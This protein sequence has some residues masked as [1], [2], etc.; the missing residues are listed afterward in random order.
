[1]MNRW[2][3]HRWHLCI[4]SLCIMIK[5]TLGWIR[6]QSKF[7]LQSN[8][9]FSGGSSLRSTKVSDETLSA[10]TAIYHTTLIVHRQ[11]G[12]NAW[13]CLEDCQ[14][15][16]YCESDR[17]SKHAWWIVS[18]NSS[19]V[20]IRSMRTRRKC[21]RSAKKPLCGTDDPLYAT[22]FEKYGGSEPVAEKAAGGR[23]EF[24]SSWK[25]ELIPS[26]NWCWSSILRKRLRVNARSSGLVVLFTVKTG[27]GDESY[28]PMKLA[29]PGGTDGAVSNDFPWTSGSWLV[30]VRCIGSC[31]IVEFRVYRG[32]YKDPRFMTKSS[33]ISPWLVFGLVEH[34]WLFVEHYAG[35]VLGQELVLLLHVAFVLSPVQWTHVSEGTRSPDRKIHRTPPAAYS[36]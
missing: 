12:K 23:R 15:C 8:D 24:D 29:N 35:W 5:K 19:S 14:L 7:L 33:I 13:M 9:F 11:N 2:S 32:N 16:L 21:S 4:I 25:W 22:L 20:R 30:L 6:E 28:G 27:D 26:L 1:M 3:S 18:M 36:A 17:G 34:V 31:M 10:C